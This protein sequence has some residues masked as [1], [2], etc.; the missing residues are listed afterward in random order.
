MYGIKNKQLKIFFFMFF[1]L[2]ITAFLTH[3]IKNK[4]RKIFFLMFL[5]LTVTAF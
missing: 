3:G 5:K 1:K 2:T 4:Q